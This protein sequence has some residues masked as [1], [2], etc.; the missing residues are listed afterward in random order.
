MGD[1]EQCR[2]VIVIIEYKQVGAHIRWDLFGQWHGGVGA[3]NLFKMI[4]Y[5]WFVSTQ[6]A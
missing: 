2:S 6:G 5:G 3:M 1:I 4:F